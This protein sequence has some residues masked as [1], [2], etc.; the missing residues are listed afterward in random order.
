MKSCKVN[1]WRILILRNQCVRPLQKA[2][3]HCWLFSIHFNS[4]NSTMVC[5]SWLWHLHWRSQR[6]RQWSSRNAS[7]KIVPL[8]QL[9]SSKVEQESNTSASE[10][11]CWMEIVGLYACV[12]LFVCLFVCFFL[13]VCLI[14]WSGETSLP[15]LGHLGCLGG[16]LC[17]EALEMHSSK[18]CLSANW[19]ARE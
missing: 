7:I 16:G 11:S 2:S 13:F 14:V 6:R 9:L 5:G 19:S 3:R 8:N 12:C 4:T 17:N 10:V 18:Q 15:N 1:F